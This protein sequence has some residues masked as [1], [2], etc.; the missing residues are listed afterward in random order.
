MI[1]YVYPQDILAVWPQASE[2]LN[3]AFEQS[4]ADTAANHLF[5]LTQDDEQLW[6][7]HDQAWAITRVTQCRSGFAV[8]EIIAMGG[9]GLDQWGSEFFEVVESWGKSNGCT[10]SIFTGRL[11]WRKRAPGYRPKR[12]TFVKEL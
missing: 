12:I 4:E 1:G 8:L 3:R 7:I 6:S 10:K 11:G 5:A 2:Q 9:A